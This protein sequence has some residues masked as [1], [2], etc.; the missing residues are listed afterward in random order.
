MNTQAAL[1]SFP[2][3]FYETSP[4][5]DPSEDQGNAS[6][7]SQPPGAENRVEK[8][9]KWIWRDK[10]KVSAQSYSS[11]IF[12]LEK[13]TQGLKRYLSPPLAKEKFSWVNIKFLSKQL[14]KILCSS[15]MASR[16]SK[17]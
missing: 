3:I 14:S 12:Y 7:P 15:S 8:G 6:H 9:G 13:I 10:E 5:E 16:K 2:L 17:R 11:E 4:P 1:S